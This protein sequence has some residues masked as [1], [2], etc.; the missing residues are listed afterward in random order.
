[1]SFRCQQCGRTSHAGEK[2]RPVTVKSRP[3]MYPPVYSGDGPTEGSEI[4]QELRV[5]QECGTGSPFRQP[6]PKHFEPGKQYQIRTAI[7]EFHKVPVVS[8]DRKAVKVLVARALWQ[9]NGTFDM[10]E[11]VVDIAV[12]AIVSAREIL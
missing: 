6:E 4:V 10:K 5:C 11:K 3:R 1:M 8:V 2:A 12:G 9:R 7:S